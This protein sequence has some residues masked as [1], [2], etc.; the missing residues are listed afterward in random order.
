MSIGGNDTGGDSEKWEAEAT[1]KIPPYI[2]A[3]TLEWADLDFLQCARFKGRSICLDLN[4]GQ[5][6]LT[7]K[8]TPQWWD[9][10]HSEKLESKRESRGCGTSLLKQVL[11]V[12]SEFYNDIKPWK[13]PAGRDLRVCPF[14]FRYKLGM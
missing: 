12:I 14:Q 3:S 1:G 9:L 11:T 10:M 2:R 13:V 7:P 4:K 5:N 6:A 8:T